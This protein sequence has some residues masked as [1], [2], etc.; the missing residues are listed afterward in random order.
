MQTCSNMSIHIETVDKYVDKYVDKSYKFYITE[1]AKIIKKS[2]QFKIGLNQRIEQ[3]W[4]HIGVKQMSFPEKIVEYI[5]CKWNDIFDRDSYTLNIKDIVINEISGFPTHI[6]H[7]CEYAWENIIKQYIKTAQCGYSGVGSDNMVELNEYYLNQLKVFIKGFN[8]RLTEYDQIYN[9][10]KQRFSSKYIIINHIEHVL[11]IFLFINNHY[12]NIYSF[13]TKWVSFQTD[14]IEFSTRI[15][16]NIKAQ[17]TNPVKYNN[18]E[19]RYMNIAIAT[20]EKTKHI[21]SVKHSKFIGSI[22]TRLFYKDIA[23]TITDYI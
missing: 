8:V 10:E 22:L 13:S 5:N 7:L 1:L 14:M 17:L 6:T 18:S 15:I 23:L 16:Q 9:E 21:I 3:S 4:N 20:L 19:Q 2:K 11:P 12:Y